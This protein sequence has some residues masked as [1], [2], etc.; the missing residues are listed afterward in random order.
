MT[1]TTLKAVAFSA[2]VAGQAL[3]GNTFK[4]QITGHGQVK[5]KPDA[6]ASDFSANND[7]SATK[8]EAEKAWNT[9]RKTIEDSLKA[10]VPG[11]KIKVQANSYKSDRIVRRRVDG[12]NWPYNHYFVDTCAPKGEKSVALKDLTDETGSIVK[13]KLGVKWSTNGSFSVTT[14][15]DNTR[16]LQD[17]L[18]ALSEVEFGTV[19]P[20]GT[21]F[22]LSL[23]GSRAMTRAVVSEKKKE[24]NR[25]RAQAKA[26]KN[27]MKLL[28][29]FKGLGFDQVPGSKIKMTRDL[30]TVMP[31]HIRNEKGE[32]T[33]QTIGLNLTVATQAVAGS[34]VETEV[35]V[36]VNAKKTFKADY[37]EATYSFVGNCFESK[38]AAVKARKAFIE[39]M[40]QNVMAFYQD[41]TPVKGVDR[42]DPADVRSRKVKDSLTTIEGRTFTTDT[43]LVAEGALMSAFDAKDE[44]VF[45][46]FR[47][48]YTARDQKGALASKALAGAKKSAAAVEGVTLNALKAT[49]RW[50]DTKEKGHYRTAVLRSLKEKEINN[51]VCDSLESDDFA[52]KTGTIVGCTLTDQGGSNNFRHLDLLIQVLS[53][54]N[55]L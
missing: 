47:E 37:F 45:W 14:S 54:L 33:A 41:K 31:Q 17:A 51:A 55:L 6:V 23:P 34:D 35:N 44:R 32:I 19:T 11:L 26:D 7:C 4:V 1:N 39:A 43:C 50:L 27:A 40:D 20:E 28:E 49:K 8:E 24:K 48:T 36:Q 3:A 5:V 9:Q 29:V 16:A 10:K 18:Q 46:S 13:E 12:S 2:L 30:Q 38:E 15:S 22:K 53:L 42:Q 52:G 25:A 21:S